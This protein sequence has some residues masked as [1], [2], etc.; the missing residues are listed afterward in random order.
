MSVSFAAPFRLV[1][2]EI[3]M[4]SDFRLSYSGPYFLGLG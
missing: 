2:N 3:S 4:A 1:D